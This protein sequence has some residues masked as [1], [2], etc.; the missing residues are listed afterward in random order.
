MRYWDSSALVPLIIP[1][2]SSHSAE[3]LVDQDTDIA[4]WWGARV[5]CASAVRRQIRD[6]T[7][8]PA[9]AVVASASIERLASQAREIPPSEHLRRLACELVDRHPLRAADALQL[10]AAVTARTA[11]AEPIDFVCLDQRL[12]L[13]AATEGFAVLPA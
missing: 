9:L 5:E 3:R 11:A 2:A 12:R 13:A 6:R 1:E 4:M 10:A 8:A 7:L